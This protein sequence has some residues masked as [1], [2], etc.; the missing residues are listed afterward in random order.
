MVRAGCWNE[1]EAEVEDIRGSRGPF[2]HENW[3]CRSTA[4]PSSHLER[5][6]VPYQSTNIANASSPCSGPLRVRRTMQEAD[7]HIRQPLAIRETCTAAGE[8][9]S[10]CS[11]GG[12]RKTTFCWWPMVICQGKIDGAH[13]WVVDM[14][15]SSAQTSLAQDRRRVA[16]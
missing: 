12:R 2:M 16:H 5:P 14:T 11:H 13:K 10:D 4:G 6:L 3:I 15:E 7:L 1:G 9:L 8:S